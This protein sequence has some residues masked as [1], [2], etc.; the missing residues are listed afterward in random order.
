M[1][2]KTTLKS[3]IRRNCTALS[4]PCPRL[5]IL[6][7]EGFTTPTTRAALSS[8]GLSIAV[9]A[10]YLPAM[11]IQEAWFAM[12]HE[13]RHLW[14]QKNAPDLLTGYT[15]SAGTALNAYAAQPAEI[16]ANAWAVIV[17]SD[18]LGMRPTFNAMYSPEVCRMI[19]DRAR[20]ILSE[21]VC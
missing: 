20:Q 5:A 19:D 17:C 10:A 16:D 1:I 2:S 11:T 14:Q 12:S 4:I 7:P 15:P 9:N 8:D 21:L 3:I 18:A 13:C 6:P